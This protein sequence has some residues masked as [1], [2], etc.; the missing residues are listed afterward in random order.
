MAISLK[1]AYYAKPEWGTITVGEEFLLLANA[2]WVA[3]VTQAFHSGRSPYLLHQSVQADGC[4]VEDADFSLN[5][6]PV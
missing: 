6:K 4:F 3:D 5:G 2:I 1:L